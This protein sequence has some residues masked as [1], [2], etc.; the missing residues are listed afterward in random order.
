MFVSFTGN[1]FVHAFLWLEIAVVM[2]TTTVVRHTLG[3]LR[4]YDLYLVRR[5]WRELAVNGGKGAQT[6]PK[7]RTA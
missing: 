3:E 4:T 2:V 7:D 1:M 6:H 5:P